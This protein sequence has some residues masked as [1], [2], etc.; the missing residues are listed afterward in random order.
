M[1]LAG[2]I[3]GTKTRL[4]LYERESGRLKLL[5]E[6]TYKSADHPGLEE[7]VRLFTA[8]H[9]QK[10]EAAGF[11]VAGPVREGRCE[12]TNLV[13]VVDAK[14]LAAGLGLK[15]ATLINDLEANAWGLPELAPSDFAILNDG[16]ARATGNSAIISAGTGLGEAGLFWDGA[17]HRP[18]GSEGGHASFA[19]SDDL[20]VEL[21]RYLRG[22][23]EHVSWE[24][25]VAGPGLHNIY[26]FLRDSGRGE[27]PEWLRQEMYAGDP[28][29]V[30]SAA[31]LSGKSP[32]CSAALDMF[33]SLYGS[34]AGNLGLTIMATGGVYVGGGI[35]PKI[36][37]RMRGDRFM[38]A[39]VSKGRMQ[40]LLEAMPVRVVLNDRT[41]LL[42]AC[43][44]AADSLQAG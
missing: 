31:G 21:Y 43:R 17:R 18:F 41:A 15:H 16:A 44:C 36:L 28:P 35:A 27:E 40:P 34:E 22:R 4:A 38:R 20:E 42:G 11:G 39:F 37:E 33:V 12:T 23:F 7:I 8:E 26:G 14:R 9:P 3:G 5:A 25:V 32:L 24:R 30:I 6:K 10:V 2:D 1:I 13:W 29:A 19:P